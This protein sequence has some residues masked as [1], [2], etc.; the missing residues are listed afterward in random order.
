MRGTMIGLSRQMY[1]IQS[2]SLSDADSLLQ[3]PSTEDLEV[4]PTEVKLTKAERRAR[5][6]E[7]NRKLWEEA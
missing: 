1:G 3:E 7:L 5:Q 4:A 2:A 6:A